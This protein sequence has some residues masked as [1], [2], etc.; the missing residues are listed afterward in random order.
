MH[1]PSSPQS[2]APDGSTCAGGLRYAFIRTAGATPTFRKGRK[3][4]QLEATV[5]TLREKSSVICLVPCVTVAELACRSGAVRRA[6]MSFLKCVEPSADPSND[7]AGAGLLDGC[8]ADPNCRICAPNPLREG[9][10]ILIP[11]RDTRHTKLARTVT[12]ELTTKWFT[13]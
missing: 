3:A 9:S 4:G 11:A 13:E 2:C 12:T 8:P 1:A 6:Q 10:P 7:E 5:Y